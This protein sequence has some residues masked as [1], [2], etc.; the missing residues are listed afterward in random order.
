M[1]LQDGIE[2]DEEGQAERFVSLSLISQKL[3]ESTEKCFVQ[4]EIAF[5]SWIGSV[6]QPPPQTWTR[7][8]S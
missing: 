1:Y 5:Y 4:L 2:K 7:E 8:D 3:E 6:A